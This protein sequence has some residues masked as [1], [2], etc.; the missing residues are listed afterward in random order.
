MTVHVTA[1][2]R[3]G[4]Y[5]DPCANCAQRYADHRPGGCP[6]HAHHGIPFRTGNVCESTLFKNTITWIHKRVYYVKN[7]ACQLLPSHVRQIGTHCVSGNDACEFGIFTL[8]LVAINLFLRKLEFT[9][10]DASNLHQNMFVMSGEYIADG[11][12]LK[13]KGKG[14]RDTTRGE[15]IQILPFLCHLP[16]TFPLIPISLSL[17]SSP[18]GSARDT[19]RGATS[20][21][22]PKM[23]YPTLIP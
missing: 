13:V 19:T 6:A 9:S 15:A 20:I 2:G 21:C 5:E 1:H 11:L 10:L 16:M 18:Q 12:H 17:S 22:G 14:V 8:L 4:Q 7:G 3:T 23:A